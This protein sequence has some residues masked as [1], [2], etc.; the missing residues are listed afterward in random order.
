MR[1][2]IRRFKQK[3]F[4]SLS[5]NQW[6]IIEPFLANK[7]KRGKKMTH[8][9]RLIVDAIL[10]I[11][12]TGAQWRNLDSKYPPY[13]S[14]FHHYAKW[15]DNGAF[16]LV[17]N[18]LVKMQ[19]EKLGR[20]TCPS[21]SAVDSQSIKIAPLIPNDKGVDGNKRI[22][23]RKRHQAVDGQGLP[24]AIHVTAA[25][26]HDGT[27]GIEMLVQLEQFSERLKLINADGTYKGEFVDAAA[28]Y[29]FEVK[30]TQKPESQKGFVPQK[31]CWQVERS[32]GWLNFYRRLSKD[33]ERKT[34]SSAAFIQL[35][36]ISIILANFY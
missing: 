2:K 1:D 18:S 3:R 17:M 15:R 19:R 11:C 24:L 7:S 28:V 5:D 9:L 22:N 27:E 36:Y 13:G 10:W 16:T 4:R 29:G 34:E 21:M 25:N 20:N 8:S 30:I 32:F 6:Q 23:G 14:V 12:R 26:A 31:G 35:A 33:Y